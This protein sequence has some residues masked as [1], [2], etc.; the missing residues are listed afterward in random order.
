MPRSLPDR[1]VLLHI[2]FY[3]DARARFCLPR[4]QILFQLFFLRAR[5][6]TDFRT[7]FVRWRSLKKKK[8]RKK[9]RKKGN[10]CSRET[11]GPA[12]LFCAIRQPGSD[13][14]N[15]LSTQ[16]QFQSTD[17]HTHTLARDYFLLK[18]CLT[19]DGNYFLQ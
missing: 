4:G 2:A 1:P 13:N 11:K 3:A 6:S 17:T 14:A 15:V 8:K 19:R 16:S 5:R 10:A 12:L 9:E 7:A 18:S